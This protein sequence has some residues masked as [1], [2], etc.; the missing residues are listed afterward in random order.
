MFYFFIYQYYYNNVLSKISNWN[1]TFNTKKAKLICIITRWYLRCHCGWS[2]QSPLWRRWS[3]AV[4]WPGAWRWM[5]RAPLGCSQA[6]RQLSEPTH[7]GQTAYVP[8][9]RVEKKNAGLKFETDR[10]I[11][12]RG[13]RRWSR[14]GLNLNK[15]KSWL[16][17]KIKLFQGQDSTG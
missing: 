4:P 8:L 12:M 14:T 17:L 7:V 11:K 6:G 15:K 13:W 9:K 10:A 2:R 16:L 5:R 1:E 3:A